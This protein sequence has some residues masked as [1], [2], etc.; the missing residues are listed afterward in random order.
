MLPLDP[1]H[2]GV[3]EDDVLG[4]VVEFLACDVPGLC[5]EGAGGVL[6]EG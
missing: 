5:A 4:D 2:V 1:V 6:V 3:C